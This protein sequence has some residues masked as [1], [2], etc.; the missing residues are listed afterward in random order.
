MV[1]GLKVC[2]QYIMGNIVTITK[3]KFIDGQEMLNKIGVE[4]DEVE[5]YR[6]LKAV[7]KGKPRKIA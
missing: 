7:V 2:R 4:S 1:Y 3:L 5:M 6:E